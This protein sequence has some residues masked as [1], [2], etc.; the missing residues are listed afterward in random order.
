MSLGVLLD[1]SV[2]VL[3]IMVLFSL[4]ASAINEFIA[5][6]LLNLRG[7]KLREVIQRQLETRR[8]MAPG[9]GGK[10]LAVEAFFAR[11]D[12]A[13]SMETA[14]GLARWLPGRVKIDGT[15]MRL[16]SAIEPRQYALAMLDPEQ[17]AGAARAEVEAVR[18]AVMAVLEGGVLDKVTVGGEPVTD[19]LEAA[20]DEASAAVAAGGEAI[21]ARLAELEAEFREVMA[22]ATGWYLRSTRTALFLIGLALAAGANVDLLRY[23]QRLMSEANLSDR[24]AVAEAL[25]SE[26]MQAALAA[27]ADARGVREGVREQVGQL[28]AALQALDVQVGWHCV[29]EGRFPDEH[30]FRSGFCPEPGGGIT[31]TVSKI[32]CWVLVA[33][34]VTLGAQFWF[35]VFRRLAGMR[36]AGLVVSGN[37]R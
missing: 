15:A 33:F 8:G 2:S 14:S 27:E 17:L 16:P 10:D 25:V 24:V 34:G 31:L 1:I 13:R 35:D 26:Q 22:R 4:V 28:Q 5:D 7:L 12:V 19:R 37:D 30:W 9:R 21:E 36:S 18:A 29:P 11:P 32:I 3:A 6:N 23:A 20:F